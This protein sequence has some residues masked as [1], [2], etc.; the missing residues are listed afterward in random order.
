MT[1]KSDQQEPI[2]TKLIALLHKVI[3]HVKLLWVKV[4]DIIV[5]MFFGVLCIGFALI[6]PFIVLKTGCH[7][8]RDSITKTK[9]RD[10]N[11]ELIGKGNQPMTLEQC[12]AQRE[13][14]RRK[15]S[16]CFSCKDDCA[17]QALQTGTTGQDCK[18]CFDEC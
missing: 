15:R 4:R 14:T 5:Q 9:C 8:V 18:A 16:W 11:V 17:E 3:R 10:L 6:L 13:K 7:F 1:I 2:T 12:K